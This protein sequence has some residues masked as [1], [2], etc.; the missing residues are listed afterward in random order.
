MSDMQIHLGS[1][2]AETRKT[3][4][5]VVAASVAERDNRAVIEKAV[6]LV[7]GAIDD[8]VRKACDQDLGELLVKGWSFAKDLATYTDTV[9]YPPERIVRVA[10][11]EHLMKITLD[12]DLSIAVAGLPIHQLKLLVEFDA[13]I[14]GAVLIIQ[15]GAITAF[16]S[17]TI[18]LTA[19][20]RWGSVELPL[21]LKTHELEIPGRIQLTRPFPLK[22]VL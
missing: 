12:P 6:S 18:G 11:A 20:V 5:A 1:V 9:K 22:R 15:A 7:S 16:E 19:K 10:L 21:N 14:T 13:K 4:D 17:G 2:L 8:G 3:V